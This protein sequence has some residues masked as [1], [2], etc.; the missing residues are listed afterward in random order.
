MVETFDNK[1]YINV[2]DYLY[3]V[4]EIQKNV[5]YSKEFDSFENIQLLDNI[6]K[7]D[8]NQCHGHYPSY[9]CVLAMPAPMKVLITICP[10]LGVQFIFS[11][12][13]LNTWSFW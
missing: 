5:T 12:L 11:R 9:F 7:M 4:R 1:L 10:T 3:G 6:K 2:L 13:I 8:T